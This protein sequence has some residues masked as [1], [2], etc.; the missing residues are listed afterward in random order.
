MSTRSE[1]LDALTDASGGLT[2][3]E[4]APL[5]P[6]CECDEQIVGRN[7]ATLRAENVIHPIGLREGATIYVFGKGPDKSP[8]NEPPV[9]HPEV[10]RAAHA[11]A[12]MRAPKPAA[13]RAPDRAPEP[14]T[15]PSPARL[16]ASSEAPMK[17]KKQLADR[18]ADALRAHGAQTIEQLAKRCDSTVGSLH[19]TMG[20]IKKKHGVGIVER[21]G[22]GLAL[23]GFPGAKRD[24]PDAGADAGKRQQ[25]PA[26][27]N[28]R[29][30]SAPPASAAVRTP[31]NG[32]A[33]FAINESGELGIEKEGGKLRLDGAEFARLREFIERT[34]SVSS[35][36][37]RRDDR[38]QLR[39]RRGRVPRHQGGHR[40][41][42]RH[43]HQSRPRG[44][45]HARGESPR[46]QALLRGRV[47]G[48][49]ARSVPRPSP[50]ARVVQPDCKHFSK[51]KGG[52][53]V[54]K[55]IRGLAWL[56][57]L[58]AKTVK[59]RVIM[60]ENVEEFEDW[61]PLG[62]DD[63]PDPLRIGLTFKIWKGKLTAL[64]YK[65]EHRMLVC[66]DYGAPTTRK[67][68]FLVARCDGQPIVWPARSDELALTD[69]RV[70]ADLIQWERPT[71]SIFLTNA[72]GK[73]YGVKRP[74][75]DNTMRRVYR[76]FEKFVVNDPQPYIVGLAHGTHAVRPGTRSHGLGEPIR[77]I[78][79]GGNDY[80]ICTPLITEHAN[81]SNPRSWRADEPLRTQCAQVKGGHF[82]LIA[83]FM[84]PR[85]GEDPNPKRRGGQGQAPRA[86]S[87]ALPMPTIVPSQNGAQLVAAFLAKHNGGHE[88]TGQS[89]AEGVHTVVARENKALVTSSLVKLKGTCRDGQQLALPLATVQAGG[90]HYAETRAYLLRYYGSNDAARVSDPVQTVTSLDRF[91]LVTVH[92]AQYVVA[93]IG[94]RMLAARELY[95]AQGFPDDYL[96]DV[97]LDGKR[98]TNKAQV[99]MVG[100]SVC[101]PVAAALARAQFEDQVIEVGLRTQWLAGSSTTETSARQAD[102]TAARG[103]VFL[104]LIT[105][106]REKTA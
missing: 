6:S 86:R 74:L 39:R 65:V 70:A 53:P 98:L 45:R 73:H 37:P 54:D 14:V 40:A 36:A 17:E 9:P 50:G 13:E 31:T 66:S 1:I 52:K 71:Y 35:A 4:L 32:H 24:A 89:L 57:I 8:V 84:V 30:P 92:G 48:R 96:I 90:L 97:E 59:P 43:R 29:A 93:D 12:A 11:I 28:G 101:P 69:Y 20:S 99:R 95:R 80:A 61:G 58:W 26:R 38:R 33:E 63:R 18:V 42:A 72:E 55:N 78:S 49:P 10:K 7:I 85:Y 94:M 23:Y 47:E 106:A 44:D 75:A 21:K 34:E 56:V 41:R 103:Q 83:P 16:A 3:K 19:Q 88:A 76:G 62:P 46:D 105:E 77:T 87:V 22:R 79:G 82:A 60:L 68:L 81:A 15:T 104:D 2:S 67:R 5:C 100:N 25:Q 102:R 27:I 51:A 91:G 64:G